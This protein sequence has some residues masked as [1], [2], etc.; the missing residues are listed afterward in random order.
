MSLTPD[1]Y[2]TQMAIDLIAQFNEYDLLHRTHYRSCFD[3]NELYRGGRDVQA[4]AECLANVVPPPVEP[5]KIQ[6]R[7]SSKK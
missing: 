1:E 5:E 7:S 2:Y 3:A 6:V 4:L